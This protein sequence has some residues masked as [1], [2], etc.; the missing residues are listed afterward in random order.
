[1]I[2]F[3]ARELYRFLQI[4]PSVHWRTGVSAELGRVLDRKASSYLGFP[5][6]RLNPLLPVSGSPPV[7]S[8]AHEQDGSTHKEG[9]GIEHDSRPHG[10]DPERGGV[11]HENESLDPLHLP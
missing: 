9:T 1:M 7:E 6:H 4:R 11:Q 8:G 3:T 5:N 2:A 10:K